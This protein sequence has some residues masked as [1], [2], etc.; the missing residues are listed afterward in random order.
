MIGG[1]HY[2]L[3]VWLQECKVQQLVILFGE[4]G[5]VPNCRGDIATAIISL[6]GG[7]RGDLETT[8][9]QTAIEPELAQQSN[10]LEQRPQMSICH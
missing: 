10:L 9:N 7:V 5:G 6:G 3:G 4:K 8:N 1:R 2:L